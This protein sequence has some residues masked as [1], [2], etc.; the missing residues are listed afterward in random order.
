MVKLSHDFNFLDQALLAIFLAVSS[1][2]GEG[3]DCVV[4]VVV[5]FLDKI[6]RSEV[7][8]SDFL[9]R[10]ELLMESF[11]VEVNFEEL[12]PL[13]LVFVGQLQN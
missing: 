8:F 9:D 4:L 10:F 3:L 5:K 2:F 11:L 7:T 1:L 12:L 6:H 13:G